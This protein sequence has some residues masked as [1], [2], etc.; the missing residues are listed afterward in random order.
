MLFSISIFFIVLRETIEA[1]LVVSILLSLVDSLAAVEGG[2]VSVVAQKQ[3]KK[4][5]RWMP[6]FAIL[7]VVVALL[8]LF[9]A[10]QA[11]SVFTAANG[12][13]TALAARVPANNN[14]YGPRGAPVAGV[15]YDY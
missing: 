10:A 2:D 15:D 3:L 6:S 14:K 13:P 9:S 7:A 1:G 5:M 8:S 12:C 11:A 4:R